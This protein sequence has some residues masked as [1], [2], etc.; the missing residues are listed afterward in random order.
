MSLEPLMP[1]ESEKA[2]T[3]Q[4]TSERRPEPS[5]AFEGYDADLLEAVMD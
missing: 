4:P 5:G 1:V 3:E 2:G